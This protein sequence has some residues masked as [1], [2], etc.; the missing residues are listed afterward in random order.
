MICKIYLKRIGYQ[1]GYDEK[2]TLAKDSSA[3]SYVAAGDETPSLAWNIRDLKEWHLHRHGLPRVTLR[4]RVLMDEGLLN[5]IA[6]VD[7]SRA[8]SDAKLRV[9][10]ACSS[11]S[12]LRDGC[13]RLEHD[14]RAARF[15]YSHLIAT[16]ASAQDTA[17]VFPLRPTYRAGVTIDSDWS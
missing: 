10:P 11:G 16:M 1:W 3:R 9:K 6:S 13:E 5:D 17:Y 8:E 14:P 15:K 4:V 7:M 12:L 2:G